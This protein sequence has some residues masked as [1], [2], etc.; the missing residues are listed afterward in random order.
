MKKITS[1]ALILLMVFSIWTMPAQAQVKGESADTPKITTSDLTIRPYW[2]N[3]AYTVGNLEKNTVY[4]SVTTY[5]SKDKVYL[6]ASIEKL[7]TYGGWTSV[8]SFSSSGTQTAFVSQSYSLS[9]HGSGTYRLRFS[10]DIYNQSGKYI[11]NTS[12]QYS[13][14]ITI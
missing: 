14:A 4:A 11:E 2:A 13:L 3:V 10:A 1:S 5:N 7:S 9:Q 8:K 6:S 12:N